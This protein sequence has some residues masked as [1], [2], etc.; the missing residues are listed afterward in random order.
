MLL[1]VVF[2]G[3]RKVTQ[4]R[5]PIRLGHVRHVI[6]LDRLAPQACFYSSYALEG[7]DCLD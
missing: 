2:E 6:T 5:F 4:R 7:F 1:V 3:N